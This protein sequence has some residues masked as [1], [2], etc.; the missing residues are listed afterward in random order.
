MKNQKGLSVDMFIFLHY[1]LANCNSALKRDKLKLNKQTNK[2]IKLAKMTIFF[3]FLT[4]E[5]RT[6][7]TRYAASQ[8][9]GVL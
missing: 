2:Q 3:F 5:P 7:S 8:E 4:A 9:N 1:L 6:H